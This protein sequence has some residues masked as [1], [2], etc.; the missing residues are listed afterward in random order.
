[1]TEL[2]S[3]PTAGH[4]MNASSPAFLRMTL[5]LDAIASGGT[6][7]LVLVATGLLADLLAIPA[8][9]LRGAGLVL[10]PYV[11][12]VA[13]LGLREQAPRPAVWAVIVANALWA[14]ASLLLLVSG[15]IAPTALGYAFIIAQALIVALFGELQYVALR[16]QA[17]A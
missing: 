11:A 5:L 7:L 14:V 13:Y 17:I 10:I 3:A 1:M 4:A 15:W 16:R 2:R 9:L 8:A 12:F 6:A